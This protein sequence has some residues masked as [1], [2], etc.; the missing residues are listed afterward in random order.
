MWQDKSMRKKYSKEEN[1]QENLQQ[2]G[3]LDS[4]IKDMMR[5]TKEGQKEIGNDRKEDNPRKEE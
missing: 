4:Q 2:K 5:N 3:Y 1:C